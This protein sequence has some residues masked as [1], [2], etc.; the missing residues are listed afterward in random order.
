MLSAHGDIPM[1]VDAMKTGAV[2]FLEK[3]ADPDVLRRKVVE[4][5]ARNAAALSDHH[6]QQEIRQHLATLTPREKQVLD[7]LAD[8]KDAHTI[9]QIFGSSHNTVRVQRASI[10]KKMRADNLADLVKMLNR[11]AG[12]GNLR[13]LPDSARHPV[14]KSVP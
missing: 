1:A 6:E 8:G 4:A 10:M 11:I 14:S 3:P 5:L 12:T 2:E 9:A 13:A 7:Y